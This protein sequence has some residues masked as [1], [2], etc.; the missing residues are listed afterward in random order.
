MARSRLS[1]TNNSPKT[2]R[3]TP[4]VDFNNAFRA[5]FISFHFAHP[6]WLH[7]FTLF[8]L[9]HC[10]VCALCDWPGWLIWLAGFM[11]FNWYPT[12]YTSHVIEGIGRL[13]WIWNETNLSIN[14]HT[15]NTISFSSNFCFNPW[16]PMV[17]VGTENLGA[18]LRKTVCFGNSKSTGWWLM[19]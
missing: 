3:T 18:K 7:V 14:L 2:N 17:A 10:I 19:M 1:S 9:V 11:A 12:V 5:V 16:Q 8:S 15:T 6:D 4:I 13:T